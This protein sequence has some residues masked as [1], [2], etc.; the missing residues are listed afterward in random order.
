MGEATF[1]S[2]DS[3]GPVLVARVAC[4]HVGERE[5]GVIQDDIF[6]RLDSGGAG[7]ALDLEE[8]RMMSSVGL[9]M[10]ITL[11]KRCA[12]GGGKLAIFGMSPELH[13]LIKLTKLERILT[14]VDDQMKAIK[15]AGG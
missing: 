15:V 6:V 1:V 7:V 12:S 10:L 4:P 11:T 9:G 3:E 14:I 2:I 8:V 13:K 5:S